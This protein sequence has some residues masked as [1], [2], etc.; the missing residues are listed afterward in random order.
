MSIAPRRGV[1]LLLLLIVA[2][3]GI[4][5]G[6]ETTGTLAGL[7]VDAQNLPVP[8]V[9]ITAAG[10][11]GSRDTITD[12]G[13]RFSIPFLTPG[14]YDVRAVL[15]S[16]KTVAVTDA[17]VSLGQTL[18]LSLKMEIGGLSESVT[19]RG[20]SVTMNTVTSTTGAVVS[21][22]FA[23]SVPIGRRVSDVAYMVP[24]VSNAG[25]VGSANPSMA[26]GTGLDNQYVIDGVNITNQGYG[27]LGAYSIYHGS[28]G[29]A[30]PFDFVEEVQVKTGGY[31][32]EFGQ[33]IGGVI[34]VVT[35]SGSNDLRGSLFGYSRPRLVERTWRTAQS[36]N[37]TVQT[38]ATQQSDG[39]A[40]TGGALVRNHLFVFGAI[41]TQWGQHTL[42]APDGFPLRARGGVVRTRRNLSYA[43]KVTWQLNGAHRVDASFFG[44]PSTG[45][46]GPQR[47]SSLT[48]SDTSSFS[49]L[50]YGGHNQTVRYSGRPGSRW[51]LEA[52]FARAANRVVETPLVDSWSVTDQTVSPNAIGGGV[53]SYEAGNE[54]SNRQWTVKSSH[55]VASHD[56]RY[57][58]EYNAVD[59]AQANQVSGPTFLAADGRTTATG[60][61]VTV[62]PDVAFG[63]IYRVDFAS[64]TSRRDTTQSYLSFFL[65][66]GWRVTNRLT[67]NPGLRYEQETMSGNE[68]KDFS[69]AGNWALRIGAAFDPTGS[70]K[71]KIFGSI[72]RFYAR[73]PNDLAAR[74]LSNE[75]DITRGDYFDAALTRP[76]PNGVATLTPGGA[77]VTSHF[78]TLSTGNEDIDPNAK[79]SYTD[80][81]VAGVERELRLGLV[82]GVH[83]VYRNLGRVLE[84]VA[85]V[86]MVAYDLGVPGIDTVRYILTN[87]SS[88][89]A[90]HPSARFLGASFDDPIHRYHALD[91]T[92]KRTGVGWSVLGSLQWSRL[93]GNYEGFYRDQ[94]GQSDPAISSIFDFPTSDPSYTA[95]GARQFGY[96]GDI[97][98]VG[99]SGILPLDRPVQ[100]KLFGTYRFSNTL[101]LAAGFNLSSGKPLTPLAANPIYTILGGEIPEAP[102]GS[103]IQT[104]D[105][106]KKRTPVLSPVD[107]QAS[108]DMPV[109]DSRRVTLLAEVFN[110]F[111]QQRPVDYDSW[112]ELQFG[113]PNPDFGKPISQVNGG[114]RF[115]APAALR[116]GARFSF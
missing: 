95:I 73:I 3:A 68:V 53:G 38:L 83:F 12:G 42:Q 86:P 64:F 90:I 7:V 102:R 54:G 103:G 109:G 8:G 96:R 29:N 101:S 11:Q 100:G 52:A 16:F 111:N 18:T 57:G 26:G 81:F 24:G 51:L 116:I 1:S 113:V 17:V 89:T 6:Q 99:T 70:G 104:V 19:V 80:E 61:Q 91:V 79:L 106:F 47:L 32:A 48:S 4:A 5:A 30:T 77:A 93:R 108:Y 72:G 33:A 78:V 36:V 112:T 67:V 44:D 50:S 35:K 82:V 43:T 25:G 37:G 66:D 105:G 56:L 63:R 28:L 62:L 2:G 65:Q 45:A 107:L 21:S 114:P 22:A 10:V 41:D 31:E 74:A 75:Q 92:V 85:N 49:R 20:D 97:R 14:A 98:H 40:E 23:A 94:N 69:L 87:P 110:L 46:M 15:D 71:S 115:Q 84:D 13:G 9:A 27:A 55:Q 59:Y 58:L 34:N 60:A 39:G 76:V 88:A